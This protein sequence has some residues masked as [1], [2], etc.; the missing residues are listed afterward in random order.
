MNIKVRTVKYSSVDL[1]IHES[2]AAAHKVWL[3]GPSG[4]RYKA[5]S[6]LT[7]DS[8]Y[9]AITLSPLP[10]IPSQEPGRGRRDY[11]VIGR[12]NIFS[13]IEHVKPP[14]IT[15]VVVTPPPDAKCLS[16]TSQAML[17]LDACG[18]CT[19]IEEFQQIYAATQV[20]QW[21][22]L[23]RSKPS[24]AF[25][26]RQLGCSPDKLRLRLPSPAKTPIKDRLGG[27]S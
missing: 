7:K 26:A 14:I 18:R 22:S 4:H 3:N 15:L 16:V 12:F 13:T 20:Q 6:L 23:I 2:A 19:P 24:R 10:V 25:M 21:E 9:A 8:L 1:T 11:G 5:H 27:P 17:L